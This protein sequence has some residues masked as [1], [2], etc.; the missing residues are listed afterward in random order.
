MFMSTVSRLL[1]AW[2]AFLLPCLATYKALSR[3]PLAEPDIQRWSMYWAVIGVFMAFEYVAEWTVSWLPF[4]WEVKTLFLL[5][6]SLPQTQGS[7]YVYTTYLQPFLSRNEADLDAGIIAIQGNVV[8]FV[9]GKLVTIWDFFWTKVGGRTQLE[10]SASDSNAPQLSWLLS[11]DLWRSAATLLPS[12]ASAKPTSSRHNSNTSSAN[13]T[14]EPQV[15]SFPI[16][17]HYE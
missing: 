10:S 8:T 9:Q 7:T 3:R 6:L 1:S 4:Y 16:P 2:F 15:P 11:A 13:S 14:G 12:S 17:Q 5:Y